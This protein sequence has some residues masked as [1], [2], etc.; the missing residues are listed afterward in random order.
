VFS[1]GPDQVGEK[2][3][4][5]VVEAPETLEELLKLALTGKIPE[6]KQEAGFLKSVRGKTLGLDQVSDADAPVDQVAGNGFLLAF[7]VVAVAHNIAYPGQAHGYAGA[8][9]VPETL[10]NV[11][12]FKVGVGN[13]GVIQTF[14]VYL[15]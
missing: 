14:S 2:V 13:V 4:G 1:G 7:L 9:L 10:F 6:Q 15:G 8:V 11:V 5:Q 3:V 12:F